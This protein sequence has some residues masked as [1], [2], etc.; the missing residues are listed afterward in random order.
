MQT[1]NGKFSIHPS[2]KPPL[3]TKP[4]NTNQNSL[5][6]HLSWMQ[7]ING[8]FNVIH[9]KSPHFKVNL[10]IH[11][12][13]LTKQTPVLDADHQRWIQCRPILLVLAHV[14]LQ[15]VCLCVSLDVVRLRVSLED[16]CVVK[17]MN[18]ISSNFAR[19]CPCSPAMYRCRR[20]ISY[21][22]FVT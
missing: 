11:K 2:N 19:S 7:T 21:V 14:P 6:K 8:E 18:S 10:R 5:N 4:E 12:L 9:Q 17:S 16:V 15:F 1:I 13:T 3:R 20:Q 22:S